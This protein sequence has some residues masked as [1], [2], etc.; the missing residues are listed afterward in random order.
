MTLNPFRWLNAHPTIRVLGGWLTLAA[1]ILVSLVGGPAIPIGPIYA[2]PVMLISYDIRLA[3][4][5]VIAV[6]AGLA[7]TV[8]ATS[9]GTSLWEIWRVSEAPPDSVAASPM[10]AFAGSA[11]P[12]EEGAQAD[13]TMRKKILQKYLSGEPLTDP[14]QAMPLVL[15]IWAMGTLGFVLVAVGFHT[16]RAQEF[17]LAKAELERLNRE[18]Q[19]LNA[20]LVTLNHE[21][22][23]P[24]AIILAQTGL[25][26]MSGGKENPNAKSIQNIQQAVTRI[27]NF[28]KELTA[29]EAV[30][31]KTVGSSFQHID[32]AAAGKTRSQSDPAAAA[33]SDSQ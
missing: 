32:W 19:I 21:I 27:S 29:I 26:E 20:I 23:N 10:A 6:V 30:R 3:R 16:I 25:M 13:M 11:A 24:L 12:A 15:S 2:L 31:L 5:L 4:G 7:W 1:L 18:Q 8:F 9:I 28:L 17:E 22:N 33:P 14:L